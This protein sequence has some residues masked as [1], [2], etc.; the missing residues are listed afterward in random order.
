VTYP[1][2]FSFRPERFIKDGKIDPDVKDPLAAFGFGRRICP[3]R[4]M[5]QASV[6][7]AAASML[8]SFDIAKAVNADGSVVEPSGE[9][10]TEMLK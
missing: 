9:Y 1:D 10:T 8:A 7:I 2:P 4:H 6:W 3:G 5:A